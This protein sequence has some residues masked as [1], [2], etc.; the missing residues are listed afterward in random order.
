MWSVRERRATGGRLD[1]VLVAIVRF[2]AG[3]IDSIGSRRMFRTG[4][5]AGEGS[6]KLLAYPL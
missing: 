5:E 3:P 2:D 4:T 1:T 6:S